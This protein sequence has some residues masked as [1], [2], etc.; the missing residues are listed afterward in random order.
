MKL[1]SIYQHIALIS[2]YIEVA[3]RKLYWRN[4][5]LL[6][7]FKSSK[8]ST[9][10][11]SSHKIDFSQII[12]YLKDNGINKGDIIIVHSSYD[13]LASSMLSPD[14]VIDMLID[15]V[16]ENGT[17]AMPAIRKYTNTPKYEDLLTS[18]YETLRV[19]DTRKSRVASGLLPYSMLRRPD[20]SVSRFPL[21]PMVA[22]GTLAKEMMKNNIDGNLPT[23]HGPNSSWKFCLDHNAYIV[24]IGVNLAL[25]NTITHVAEEAYP[26][27]PIPNW[28][29]QSDFLIKDG[30]F[31]CKTTI[32]ERRLEKS[33]LHYAEYNLMN[34]IKKN[35]ILK[36]DIIE[37]VKV[38]IIN[39]QRYISFLRSHKHKG[40]PYYYW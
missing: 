11:F 18:D 7:R 26:D 10:N 16:G 22:I 23:A 30:D 20:C 32:N 9:E 5:K 4:V 36:E 12:N 28:Y 40:Y 35:N 34:D 19:Y 33:L 31:E 24:G 29:K 8:A 14:E 6:K 25:C 38:G 3:L 21:N 39:S 15:L 2:P 13:A 17:I 37:G 27:W 1:T